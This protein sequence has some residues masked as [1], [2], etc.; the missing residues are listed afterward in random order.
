MGLC[1][2]VPPGVTPPP[3]LRNIFAEL[4]TDLGLPL[5]SSGDLTPWAERGV[6]LLNSVLTVG[7]GTP[8]SHAGKGWEAFTDRVIAELSARREGVV[9]LL[10]GRYAQQKGANL[11]RNRLLRRA[12][13]FQP[14]AAV[15]NGAA[16]AERYVARGR[17][18]ADDRLDAWRDG[19]SPL[20]APDNRPND[21]FDM[22]PIEAMWTRI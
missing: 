19:S 7:P 17:C 16:F 5:P 8:A 11:V 13:S 15:A 14:D 4:G 21:R 3:S 22:A 18:P 2:S 10:W 1:F 9:F 20:P 12:L 6:L